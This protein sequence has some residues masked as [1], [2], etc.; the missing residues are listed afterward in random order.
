MSKLRQ[1]ISVSGFF[2]QFHQRRG[3][4]ETQRA[5]RKKSCLRTIFLR[6]R[7]G[8][9][10]DRFLILFFLFSAS[11]APLLRASASALMGLKEQNPNS[12]M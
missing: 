6:D 12:D 5:Q 11:S 10:G 3:R 8:H 1:E 9:G 4:A 7:I 2:S